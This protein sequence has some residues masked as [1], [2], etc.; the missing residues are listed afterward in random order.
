MGQIASHLGERENGKL[1]SQS[2]PNL[3]GQFAVENSLNPTHK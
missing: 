2:V 1:P 3:K